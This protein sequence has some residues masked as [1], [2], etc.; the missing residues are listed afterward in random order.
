MRSLQALTAGTAFFALLVTTAPE[1]GLAR[2]SGHQALARTVVARAETLT[3]RYVAYAEV[4][5][6][7]LLPVRTTR[8]GRVA[9]LHVLPGDE[10][11]AGE[12]LAELTGPNVRARLAESR[13]AAN[14]AAKQEQGARAALAIERQRMATHQSTQQAVLAAENQLAIARASVA[15]ANAQLEASRK[16]VRVRATSDGTVLA[17]NATNGQEVVAGATLLTLQPAHGLW[18]KA[19]FYGSD[20]FAIH[21]GMKGMFVPAGSRSAEAIPIH[22]AT[23][24][25]ALAPD[26]GRRVA[27]A[28]ATSSPGWLNGE[29]GTVTLNGTSRTLP[30]VPTE[31][32]I[33]ARGKWWLLVHK[34]DGDRP[35]QVVP[36]PSRGWHTFI[37]HGLASGSEVV[38]QNAYLEFH[39]QVA[40]KYQPP[41]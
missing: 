28:A 35:V 2:S 7:T 22:V 1:I 20:A 10:V 4:E 26:G 21:A 23:I 12:V 32:L 41:D 13:A 11:H 17:V 15:T 30:V 18:V 9:E 29:A 3:P 33:V 14:N 38:A 6:T 19:A 8:A 36:G 31:A 25:A 39:R 5:P 24:Y 40:S 34:R 27:L 37:T 16:L